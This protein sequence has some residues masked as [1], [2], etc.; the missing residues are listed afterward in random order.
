MDCGLFN[1]RNCEKKNAQICDINLVL[2]R[3]DALQ[4]KTHPE[5]YKKAFK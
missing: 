5:S 3:I 2:V 4:T 1:S